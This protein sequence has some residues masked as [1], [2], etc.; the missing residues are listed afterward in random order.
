MSITYGRHLA[1]SWGA[2]QRSGT[3]SMKAY[4]THTEESEVRRT[5]T[6][7]YRGRSQGGS[8]DAPQPGDHGVRTHASAWSPTMESRSPLAGA[9]TNQAASLQSSRPA[10]RARIAQVA[11]VWR[12]RWGLP[13]RRWP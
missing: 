12:K 8:D 9:T 6:P 11:R 2:M 3:V 5:A 13:A 10:G 1:K 7:G 4:T